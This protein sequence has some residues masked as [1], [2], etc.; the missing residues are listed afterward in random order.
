MR[1]GPGAWAHHDGGVPASRELRDRLRWAF[2]W[3]GDRWDDGLLADATGWWRDPVLLGDLVTAMAAP[4]REQQPTVVLGL[5]SRRVLLGA[6]VAQRLGIGLVEVRKDPNP[7]A[8]SDDWVTTTT[9][10][11]YRDRHLM[12]GFRRR[13]SRPTT[14]SCWWTTGSRP[15]V[16][17]SA[18][19]SWWPP[20]GP[21][22]WAR[23]S[24][25]MGVARS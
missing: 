25:W 13:W 19:A 3:R 21:P 7:A 23:R 10:P 16:R 22:G 11:D 18:S 20:F 6:L 24:S 8:D 15:A 2:A 12:L 1:P 4:L 14:A 9:P 17:L 5:A